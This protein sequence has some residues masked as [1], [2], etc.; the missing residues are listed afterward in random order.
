MAYEFKYRLNSAP[1]ARNDGSGCVDHDIEA[2]V[3][4]DGGDWTVV[5]ARHKTISVPA[6]ELSAALATGTNAQKVTAYKN[7]LAVN[8]DTQPEPL[9]GWT[10]AQMTEMLDNNAAALAAATTADAFILVVKP[11]GYPVEFSM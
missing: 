5:P 6:A 2:I 1:A 3:S 8:L 4:V 10:I 7:A 9:V 11:S